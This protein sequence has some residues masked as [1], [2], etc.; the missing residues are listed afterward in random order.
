MNGD[1]IRQLRLDKF[2][3]KRFDTLRD[4][5]RADAGD[6]EAGEEKDGGGDA[7]DGVDAPADAFFSQPGSAGRGDSSRLAATRPGPTPEISMRQ[8]SRLAQ[9]QLSQ[10]LSSSGGGA[11]TVTSFYDHWAATN[12]K[13]SEGYGRLRYTA[14]QPRAATYGN[15]GPNQ[16]DD[17]DAQARASVHAD[18]DEGAD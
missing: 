11:N 10:T 1:D 9:Q 3:R 16:E 5:Q 7:G 8:G 18:S 14:P 12:R 4:S 15:P 13:P 2:S 17:Q 6:D